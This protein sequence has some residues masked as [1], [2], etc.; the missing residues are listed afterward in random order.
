VGRE[1]SKNLKAAT[2]AICAAVRALELAA[3]M[4]GSLAQPNTP[5]LRLTF[6]SNK[7][8]NV[9][10]SNDPGYDLELAECVSEVTN[11]FDPAV[12]NHFRTLV[13]A[14]KSAILGT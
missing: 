12:I 5:G 4:D 1:A 3:R 13:E 8:V 2:S 6:T 11:N 7:V 14:S 10:N 9:M